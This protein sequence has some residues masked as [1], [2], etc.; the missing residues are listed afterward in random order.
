MMSYPT[1]L[2]T[3]GLLQLAG[4]GTAALPVPAEAEMVTAVAAEADMVVE[5]RGSVGR[6]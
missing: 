5:V 1:K 3:S 2:R 6:R 4:W